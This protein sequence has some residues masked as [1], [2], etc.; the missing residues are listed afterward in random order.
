MWKLTLIVTEALKALL[1][2]FSP[3]QILPR[4]HLPYCA[5]E[6]MPS[7]EQWFQ[8]V[9]LPRVGST[10]IIISALSFCLISWGP[11]MRGHLRLGEGS[12]R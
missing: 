3:S 7:Q 2:L 4:C 11:G 8:E 5:S 12:I 1:E 10:C 9:R 6:L